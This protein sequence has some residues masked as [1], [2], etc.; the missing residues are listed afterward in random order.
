VSQLS[1]VFLGLSLTSSWGNGHATTYRGLVREL[2]RRGH[3]V[4]FLERDVPYYAENRD[5]PEPPYGTT[6]LYGSLAELQDRFGAEVAA[7]DAVIVGSYVPDGV[8]VGDWV[9]RTAGGVRVFYDIDTPITI[10]ALERGTPTYIEARQIPRYDLYLSFT[11]GP[12]LEHIASHFRAA[13]VRP[14]CCSADTETYFPEPRALEW[15]LGYLGTY[16]VDRQPTLE[17]LLIEPARSW[18]QGRFAVAGPQYPVGL[19]WPA[20]VDRRDHV[21][22]PEH[23]AFYCAQRY[24]LNITRSAML[25]AGYSPSIRLFEAGACAIPIISDVWP[26]VADFF[27]P[28]RELFLASSSQEVLEILRN[29]PEDER[30]AVGQRGRARVL[31]QH[32]A[33]HRAQA[34][35]DYVHEAASSNAR[36]K[37]RP[38]ER[39]LSNL[40]GQS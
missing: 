33:A 31:A 15:D 5:L 20:N 11:T 16:S 2:V 26:G 25:S 35:E 32:T 1:F 24:T 38:V 10:D 4:T 21:P 36:H 18:E 39:L 17:R 34:L 14:L 23:R 7:A 22:P 6:R 8:A 28:G 29:T 40:R 27:V 13:R 19:A 12:L 30:V 3:E 9:C 37:R